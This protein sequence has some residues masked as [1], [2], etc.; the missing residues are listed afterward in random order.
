M[1]LL[2]LESIR[3][4]RFVLRP[5]KGA[6]F[7]GC[8]NLDEVVDADS[9]ARRGARP[10]GPDEGHHLRVPEDAFGVRFH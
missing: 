3:F 9:D 6:A 5:G 8:G 1:P 2:D 7:E 10:N 4:L